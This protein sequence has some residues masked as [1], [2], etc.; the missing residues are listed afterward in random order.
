[1]TPFMTSTMTMIIL[2]M[3]MTPSMT[4]KI[5]IIATRE[6]TTAMEATKIVRAKRRTVNGS[7]RHSTTKSHVL[8]PANEAAPDVSHRSGDKRGSV[9]RKQ[10]K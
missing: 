7:P 5:E 4:A 6:R 1:M 10:D 8:G 9:H 2:L 3:K